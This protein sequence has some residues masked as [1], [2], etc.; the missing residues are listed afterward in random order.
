LPYG[1]LITGLDASA[2]NWWFD[3]TLPC[4]IP[5]AHTI[6]Y[7]TFPTRRI[8]HM[9]IITADIVQYRGT[10]GPMRDERIGHLY[11]IADTFEDLKK[12]VSIH[13]QGLRRSTGLDWTIEPDEETWLAQARK[14]AIWRYGYEIRNSVTDDWFWVVAFPGI[15]PR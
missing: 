11:N 4:P 9:P 14:Q 6:A 1:T 2:E 5:Y 13:M 15:I 10:E 12:A 8:P 7:I 3:S